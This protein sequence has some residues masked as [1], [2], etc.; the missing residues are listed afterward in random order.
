MRMARDTICIRQQLRY[1]ILPDG[2]A[3][4]RSLL[5][6]VEKKLDQLIRPGL[7]RRESPLGVRRERLRDGLALAARA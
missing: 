6:L 1:W 4:V 5:Q 7:R 3:V 2:R